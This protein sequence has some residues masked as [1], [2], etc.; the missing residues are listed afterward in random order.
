M[1]HNPSP[2]HQTA[3]GG[4]SHPGVLIL[5]SNIV[6]C[7]FLVLVIIIVICKFLVLIINIVICKFLV[8]VHSSV[9]FLLDEHNIRVKIFRGT[10]VLGRFL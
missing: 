5:F 3:Q 7:K 9:T 6:I 2:H 10:E 1:L 4:G 8:L